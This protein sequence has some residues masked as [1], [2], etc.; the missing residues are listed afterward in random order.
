MRRAMPYPCSGPIAWSVFSTIRSS[1][2]YGTSER[3]LMLISNTKDRSSSVENQQETF[4]AM[5]AG[6]MKK[7][8]LVAAAAILLASPACTRTPE[9]AQTSQG[10]DTPRLDF[11]KYTL[12]NGLEVSLAQEHRL[13]RVAVNLWYHVSPANGEP[14]R[15]G[16]AHLFEH[17]MFQG[18]KPV[19]GD[20]QFRLAEGA[21]G[22]LNGTTVFD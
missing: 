8:F 13:P 16:F 6:I 14:G 7:L 1:V 10:A 18:S 17:M 4:C 20:S 9:T 3:S 15:T 5:L 11:A 19:P 2:P 22:N 12:P 21:G